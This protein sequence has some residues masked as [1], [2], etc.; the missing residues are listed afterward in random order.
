MW[1]L[2]LILY[3]CILS[4][5][6]KC[7]S[8]RLILFV[9]YFINSL[10]PFLNLHY[11]PHFQ[12]ILYLV[13]SCTSTSFLIPF[14]LLYF[15]YHYSNGLKRICFQLI[16]LF[17]DIRINYLLEI[18]HNYCVIY[19]L[20]SVCHYSHTFIQFIW[21]MA[22]IL[23]L[24]RALGWSKAESK[25]TNDGDRGNRQAAT[26]LRKPSGSHKYG[27]IWSSMQAFLIG[28][29]PVTRKNNIIPSCQE[30]T[31]LVSNETVFANISGGM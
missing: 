12:I 31:A 19:L 5:F 18:T 8:I 24:H 11:F 4:N 28:V 17:F 2:S 14:S 13:L 21:R 16:V 3:L 9:C 20:S 25:S 29:L 30:S 27:Y 1:K 7:T 6:L 26:T 15:W 23:G 10:T 22:A